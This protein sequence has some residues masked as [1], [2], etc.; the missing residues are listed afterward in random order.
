[1]ASRTKPLEDLP[2]IQGPLQGTGEPPEVVPPALRRRRTNG[3]SDPAEPAASPESNGDGTAEPD[4]RR[5]RLAET[6]SQAGEK[7]GETIQKA[8]ERLADAVSPSE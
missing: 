5:E 1:L 6:I 3:G 4:S 8:A 2:I 7:A